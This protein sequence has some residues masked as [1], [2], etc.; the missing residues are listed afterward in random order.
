MQRLGVEWQL[1][2]RSSSQDYCPATGLGDA[3]LASLMRGGSV[4]LISGLL[5]PII[6]KI[7]TNDRREVQV[8]SSEP[9][10]KRYSI[11]T[12]MKI[13]GSQGVG[14]PSDPIIGYF[15]YNTVLL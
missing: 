3:I 13:M 4:E 6:N 10:Q 2:A 7:M 12:W 1:L 9:L 15:S 14:I 11:L 5:K 8:E